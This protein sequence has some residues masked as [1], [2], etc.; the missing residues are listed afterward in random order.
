MLEWAHP[1][2]W[3]LLPLPLLVY[4]FLPP[5]K[6]SKDS[7]RV[8]FFNRLVKVS[9]KEPGIGSVIIQKLWVQKIWL[10]V[11]WLL[12][13]SSIAKPEWVGNPIT[14]EHSAR[15]LMIAVDLSGSMAAED[16]IL[17]TGETVDRLVAVKEVLSEF[18]TD[19]KQDRLGLIVFGNAPYLQ[20]PF[21]QDHETW[22]TLLNETEIGMAGP[23]TMMG[24]AIGLA[25]KLFERSE[26]EN[27][28]LIML[29]DGND[30]G[31]RMPPI[32]AAKIAKDRGVILYNI[33]IGDPAT[34]GEKA[35]D[36][37]TLERMSEITGGATYHALHREELEE[38]YLEINKLEPEV[39]ESLSYRPRQSLH[40]FPLILV[41]VVYL[42]LFGA[43]TG[44]SI[45]RNRKAVE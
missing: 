2:M 37:K 27:R 33:A 38:A 25:I 29:T 9:K 18:I 15:D 1:W 3:T 10:I 41:T 19:R 6:S 11:S 5:Y 45:Q 23:S 12:V 32:E 4:F 40:H 17:D 22:L 35:L 8:P 24:D 43:L 39:F 28:V 21:T 14:Q 42:L 7:V 26:V 30:T 36:M 20:A 44:L 31:S 34:L 13:I 16:F